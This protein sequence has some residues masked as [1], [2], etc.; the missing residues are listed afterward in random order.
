MLAFAGHFIRVADPFSLHTDLD[1]KQ[2]FKKALDP[3]FESFIKDFLKIRIQIQQ[4]IHPDPH[5]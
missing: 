4:M 2:D 1:R 3:H 5:P